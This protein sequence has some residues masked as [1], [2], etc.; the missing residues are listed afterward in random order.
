LLHLVVLLLSAFSQEFITSEVAARALP[1][2][3]LH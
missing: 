2:T 3:L 1:Q